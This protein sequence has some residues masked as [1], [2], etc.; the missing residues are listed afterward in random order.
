M[1][2]QIIRVYAIADSVER[3][4]EAGV[5]GAV[6]GE[7]MRDLHHRPRPAVGTPASAKKAR[8][9]LA[10]KLN[11]PAGISPSFVEPPNGQYPCQIWRGA[12]ACQARL[13]M[14]NFFLAELPRIG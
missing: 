4:G 7:A 1:A 3:S 9:I 8:A 5:A 10:A 12:S 11:S 2:A 14:R 13:A 6:F